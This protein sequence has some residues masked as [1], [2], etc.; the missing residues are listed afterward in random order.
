MNLGPGDSF[1]PLVRMIFAGGADSLLGLL[2]L[3][4]IVAGCVF[5]LGLAVALIVLFTQAITSWAFGWT[6][7]RAGLLVDLAIEPL[8]F[9]THPLV[10]IDWQTK[11]EGLDGIVHSWTYAHPIAIQHLQDWVRS[12]LF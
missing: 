9:G 12:K 7:L 10:H 4:L 1:S 11:S 5:F 8:P 3:A 2:I 6:Q